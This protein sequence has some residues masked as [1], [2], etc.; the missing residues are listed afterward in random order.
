MVCPSQDEQNAQFSVTDLSALNN[1][2]GEHIFVLLKGYFDGG[3]KVDS[4]TNKTATLAF[5]TGRPDALKRLE[6]AWQS[7]LLKHRAEYLSTTDAA[8]LGGIYKTGWSAARRDDFLFDCVDLIKKST[9]GGLSTYG[10]GLFSVTIDLKAFK[11]A[12]MAQPNLPHD[13]TVV[14]ASQAFAKLLEVGNVL[15]AHFLELLFD[16]NEPFR[17]HICDRIR[18]PKYIREMARNKMDIKRRIIVGP[19]VD[20]R[21]ASVLQAA[22]L[23]AWSVN[24]R[25]AIKFEWQL[26][27]LG[28]PAESELIDGGAL[29]K[30]NALAMDLVKYCNFPRR[31]ATK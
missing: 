25:N 2:S 9:E 29:Q 10:L 24:R 11:A 30:P 21:D 1:I 14:L 18:N 28:I 3:N 17:G 27:M 6:K 7:N 12:Y 26:A 4:R 23:L 5:V 13:A 22:D 20:M 16:Q 8:A 31:A 15:D 19:E